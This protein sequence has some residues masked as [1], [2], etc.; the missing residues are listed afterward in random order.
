MN[1]KKENPILKLQE[2]I[3]ELQKQ[4]EVSEKTISSLRREN[5][6]LQ[7][8]LPP[9]TQ[10]I[11]LF[12]EVDGTLAA[13]LQTETST[14]YSI[15]ISEDEKGIAALVKILHSRQGK[16]TKAFA[17]DA[18]PSQSRVDEMMKEWKVKHTITAGNILKAKDFEP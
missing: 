10:G 8:A 15:K 17:S 7:D 6:R 13:S 1:K 16:L 5:Y 4:L 11:Y 3:E 9:P 14:R 18:C 12:L 2:K